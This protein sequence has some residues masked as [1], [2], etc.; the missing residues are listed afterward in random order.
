M[1]EKFSK[2]SV[3]IRRRR[4]NKGQMKV[5]AALHKNAEA[6]P[7]LRI[8]LEALF[9]SFATKRNAKAQDTPAA[10]VASPS[11]ESR[12]DMVKRLEQHFYYDE[13]AVPG[14]LLGP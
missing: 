5:S 6:S 7:K 13:P 8:S 12:S 9:A 1:S 4:A 10:A 3:T 14:S 11:E 2:T